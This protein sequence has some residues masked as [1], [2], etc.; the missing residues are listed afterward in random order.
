MRGVEFLN[1]FKQTSSASFEAELMETPCD[2]L[3]GMQGL[4]L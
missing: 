1:Q 3:S 2:T 4:V